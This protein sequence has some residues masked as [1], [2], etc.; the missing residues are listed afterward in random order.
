MCNEQRNN[1]T[2][3]QVDTTSAKMHSLKAKANGKARI[4]RH[5]RLDS[6][7]EQDHHHHQRSLGEGGAGDGPGQTVGR[8]CG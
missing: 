7:I 6:G 4:T 2:Q 8:G 1:Q 5:T 3:A